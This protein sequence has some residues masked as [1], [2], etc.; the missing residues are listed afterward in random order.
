MAII[1]NGKIRGK[2]GKYVYRIVEDK[3]I[4]QSFPEKFELSENSKIESQRFGKSIKLAASIYQSVKD[5]ALNCVKVEFYR[6]LVRICRGLQT[7]GFL[8]L[9]ED[10]KPCWKFVPGTSALDINKVVLLN[11][12][13]GAYPTASFKES[14][15]TVKIPGFNKETVK[16]KLPKEAGFIEFTASV[17]HNHSSLGSYFVHNYSSGLLSVH[18]IIPEQEISLPV[19]WSRDDLNEGIVLICFG[20]RFYANLS[21]RRDLN[22]MNFNPTAILGMWHKKEELISS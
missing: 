11:A 1:K 19:E 9:E 16:G 7:L 15:C 12:I 8:D 18:D 13:M 3:E 22:N 2:I 17:L 20:L 21:S 14:Q 4:I 5:F 10:E 6:E